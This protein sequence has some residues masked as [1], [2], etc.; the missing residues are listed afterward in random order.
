MGLTPGLEAKQLAFFGVGL[1]E[2]DA[3][4]LGHLVRLGSGRLQQLAVGGVSHRLLSCT[5]ESTITRVNSFLMMRL[6]ITATSM[7]RAI[8]SFTPSSPR[9][10]RKRPCGVGSHDPG[11]RIQIARNVLPSGSLAPALDHVIVPLVEGMLEIQQ[12]TIN[13]VGRRERPALETPPPATTETGA[14]NSKY[15]IFLPALISRAQRCT[16]EGSISCQGIR[17][18]STVCRWRKSI[19]WS[20]RLRKKSSIVELLSK[21]PRKRALNIYLKVL[22]IRIQMT[23]IQAGCGCFAGATY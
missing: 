21:T 10:L 7:V 13:R 3:L 2:L 18:A 1:F 17:L 16:G 11:A 6:R 23:N 5:V 9:A 4:S 22:T 20:R 15:S 12:G 14:N 19:I 8:S